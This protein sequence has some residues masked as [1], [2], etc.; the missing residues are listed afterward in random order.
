MPGPE[1]FQTNEADVFEELGGTYADVG[2]FLI[3]C[4]ANRLEGRRMLAHAEAL[5]TEQARCYEVAAQ[6][7]RKWSQQ[8]RIELMLLDHALKDVKEMADLQRKYADE[9]A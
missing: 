6:A 3:E 4:R 1:T 5:Y 7:H 2:Q 9:G 8:W